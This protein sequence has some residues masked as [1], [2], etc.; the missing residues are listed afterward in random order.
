MTTA[1]AKK[2]CTGDL[3]VSTDAAGCAKGSVCCA[4]VRAGSGKCTVPAGFEEGTCIASTK[5]STC[6]KDR[7]AVRGAQGCSKTSFCCAKKSKDTACKEP[8]QTTMNGF[9]HKFDWSIPAPFVAWKK[10]EA[11]KKLGIPIGVKVFFQVKVNVLLKTD[12]SC[13]A[14]GRTARFNGVG[15]TLEKTIY[16]PFKI[17]GAKFAA[18]AAGSVVPGLNVAIM[19]LQIAELY[20]TAKDIKEIVEGLVQAYRLTKD[21]LS[22][23]NGTLDRASA[24]EVYPK[25]SLDRP[26][27]KSKRAV[28][29]FSVGSDMDAV[30]VMRSIVDP[31][32]EFANNVIVLPDSVST[33]ELPEL[34]LS[35]LD[36]EL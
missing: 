34:D 9:S 2:S 32:D 31:A 14:C 12:I 33:L 25:I 1:K 29:I 21:L 26:G 6:A 15:I 8:S 24:G 27:K 28:N 20:E 30:G 3:A 4:Q 13:I 19:A 23:K 11:V 5:A 17:T 7:E 10:T 35:H 36:N 18:Y 16:I 22:C